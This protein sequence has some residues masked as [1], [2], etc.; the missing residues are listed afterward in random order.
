MSSLDQAQIQL[1]SQRDFDRRR[2]IENL[3]RSYAK[4]LAVAQFRV[5]VAERE[6]AQEREQYALL[7]RAHEAG[8]RQLAA[9]QTEL[10]QV[11]AERD[12]LLQ[13]ARSI[14]GAQIP[15]VAKDESGGEEPTIDELLEERS[16]VSGLDLI[17]VGNGHLESKVAP[18]D[19]ASCE[20]M[21]APELVF[22]A[23]DSRAR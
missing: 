6:L 1:T 7:E 11:T 13:S 4:Q 12:A 5:H 22:P 23:D 2:E 3:E 17:T 19:E 18:A 16:W 14:N 10:E 8:K 20:E 21:I 15:L 9:M